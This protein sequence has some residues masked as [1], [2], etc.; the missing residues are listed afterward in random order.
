MIPQLLAILGLAISSN[1]DTLGVGLA[2]G[3]RKYRLPFL[4]NFVCALIPCL[5]TC[6]IMVL[7]TV[8]RGVISDQLAN[9][10]GAAIIVAA[11]AVFIIQSIQRNR[12][13]HDDQL[14]VDDQTKKPHP[15][16]KLYSCLKEMGKILEDYLRVSHD[17]SESIGLD[18]ALALALTLTLNNLSCGFAAGLVGLNI[19][20]FVGAS[21]IVSLISFWA[22][23]KIGLLYISRWLGGQG[24]FITGVML[25]ILGVYE[26]LT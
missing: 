9:V 2:Y 16:P 14:P 6:L 23:I 24:D 10:L 13:A 26:F 20:L 15:I 5:G 22:G 1:L 21:F 3:T 7:G 4:S 17:C 19:P 25:I 18:Q 11:G 12:A 8:V